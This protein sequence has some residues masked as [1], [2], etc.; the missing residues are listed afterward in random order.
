VQVAVF[1]RSCENVTFKFT[2]AMA[3]A[4]DW[5][6]SSTSSLIFEAEAVAFD[7][8][9]E[10]LL[11]FAMI[12][13]R[14]RK[15][16]TPKAAKAAAAKAAASGAPPESALSAICL[17]AF[18]LLSLN[19]HSA[20]ALP[21]VERR[22]WLHAALLSTAG[23]VQFAAGVDTADPSAVPALM[24]AALAAG[25]EG[26]MIKSLDVAASAYEPGFRSVRNFKLKRDYLDGQVDTFDLV[27]VGA[28]MGK[29][30]RAG[31]FGA[32]LLACVAEGEAGQ[33]GG[34]QTVC[35]CGSGFS[36]AEMDQ[37]T[38][39]F[40]DNGLCVDA[41][42]PELELGKL[43][44]ARQPDVWLRPEA[45]WEVLAAEISPSPTYSAASGQSGGRGVAL[46]FPRFI[47]VR[48]DKRVR[49]ATRAEQ[50]RSAL[51]QGGTEERQKAGGAKAKAKGE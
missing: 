22:R 19:G 24:E 41:P 45:V 20:L 17:F 29:G 21:F 3:H 2:S 35:K 46:R 26:L 11:P 33:A 25:C 44:R 32:F 8:E 27:P 18:D 43:A 30:K 38:A 31:R 13:R 51:E 16:P 23:Y 4:A 36:D 15:A 40:K 34:L 6:P 39:F 28:Y 5:L 49:D 48:E 1:S 7:R 37:M 9:N 14:P 47:R 12:A 10:R 42:A 50:I